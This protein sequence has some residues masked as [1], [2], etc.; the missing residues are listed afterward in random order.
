M[1]IFSHNGACPV[2]GLVNKYPCPKNLK[3]ARAPGASGD[4][5]RGARIS[6]TRPYMG[7]LR[8]R[9]PQEPRGAGSIIIEY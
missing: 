7:A 4:S 6:T 1:S 2:K 3:I 5:E 9:T 8:C